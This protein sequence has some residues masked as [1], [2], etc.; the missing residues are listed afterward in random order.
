MNA[1]EISDLALGALL[2]LGV[3][4]IAGSWLA[5]VTAVMP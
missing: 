5:I 3:A 4:F 2:M 1:N